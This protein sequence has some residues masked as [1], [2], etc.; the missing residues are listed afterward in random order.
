MLTVSASRS[1]ASKPLAQSMPL[2]ISA[3]ATLVNVATVV[4]GGFDNMPLTICVCL[5]LD[6]VQIKYTMTLLQNAKVGEL[7]R[8]VS[9]EGTLG[10][11][12]RVRELGLTVGAT[13]KLIR[14][15]PFG[16]AIEVAVQHRHLGLRLSGVTVLVEAIPLQAKS[17]IL[18]APAQTAELVPV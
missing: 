17:A 13:C 16:G 18:E 11:A 8:V 3:S 6:S 1:C 10:S 4:K 14:R 9:V 7:Y 5:Y 2:Q 12:Q 15:M